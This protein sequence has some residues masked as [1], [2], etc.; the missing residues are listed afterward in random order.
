MSCPI[1]AVRAK[2]ILL[3]ILGFSRIKYRSLEN[4][5]I[6]SDEQPMALQELEKCK[7]WSG[8]R[9]RTSWNATLGSMLPPIVD[10]FKFLGATNAKKY[11]IPH[12]TFNYGRNEEWVRWAVN[13][14]L[15]TCQSTV[16]IIGF[17]APIFFRGTGKI[18]SI[19]IRQHR[20]Q[21][22]EL[23]DFDGSKRFLSNV[24]HRM[25]ACQNEN[26]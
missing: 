7:V 14:K 9:A 19:S 25:L 22:W 15:W 2:I 5:R 24:P 13:L 26:K 12:S 10:I 3:Y 17:N 23:A 16:E 20:L 1:S 8:L 4:C 21:P 18:L 11:N 6:W